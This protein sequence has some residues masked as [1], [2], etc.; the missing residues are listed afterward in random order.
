MKFLN[1]SLAVLTAVKFAY[2]LSGKDAQTKCSLASSEYMPCYKATYVFDEDGVNSQLDKMCKEYQSKK[3]QNFFNTLITDGYIS[4]C[5]EWHK[6]YKYD[7]E[8]DIPFYGRFSRNYPQYYQALMDLLCETTIDKKHC[9]ISKNIAVGKGHKNE[10]IIYTN[11]KDKQC[12]FAYV[13]LL[14]WE[15]QLNNVPEEILHAVD[16]VDGDKC[17]DIFFENN[18]EEYERFYSTEYPGSSKTSTKKQI[19]S[20]KILATTTTE[21]SVKTTTTTTVKPVKTTTTTTVSPVKTTTT[22]VKPIKTTTTTTTT[23]KPV[24]TTT[25]TTTTVKPVK[26]TTTTTTTVKPVKTTTTTTT[27]VKPIKTTTTTTTTVKPVKTTTKVEIKEVNTSE[28]VYLPIT[29]VAKITTTTTT[30]P[31]KPLATSKPIDKIVSAV[32]GRCGPEYGACAKATECCSK[33]GW[34]GTT[35]EHCGV[36]CQSEF[37]KCNSTPSTPSTPSKSSSVKGKCGPKYGAC[38]KPNECCSQY[39]WCGTT[40][41]HCGVGCQSEF[42]NC[43][44]KKST[45]SKTT[46]SKV[47]ISTVSGRCGPKFG[48]C[49]H[50][51]Y[52]CSK[53]G[54]CGSTRDYC[55]TGCQ[56]KYGICW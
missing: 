19:T 22:T 45:P 35:E 46:K 31:V 56:P 25:T 16:V 27:T 21:K 32:R 50:S 11:C 52:C 18:P 3:C 26:T 14:Q 5:E 44:N 29:T 41:E 6:D 40:E 34:C 8:Y 53:Y 24:K 17:Q 51:G 42:G 15:L 33:Y 12:H 49:A 2:A 28:I 7:Q 39:G 4:G 20:T 13:K 37:G 38:A 43:N 1:L 47:P 10:N 9:P 23:V 30:A 48:A 55:S 54:Y 36:G